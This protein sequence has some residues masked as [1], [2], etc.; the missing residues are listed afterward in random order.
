MVWLR[1]DFHNATAQVRVPALPAIL[2]VGQTRRT[3]KAL[4][5]I[6]TCCCGGIRGTQHSNGVALDVEREYTPRCEE[7]WTIRVRA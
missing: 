4:C 2:S 6:D 5:G 3:K 7:V 1:S